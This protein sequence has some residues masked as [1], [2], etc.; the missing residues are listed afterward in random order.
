M[1][2]ASVFSFLG[3]S[4]VSDD[5]GRIFPLTITE[6]DFIGIDVK[7]IYK[8]I[9]TDVLERTQGLNEEQESVLWDNCLMSESRDG[10]VTMLAK[11]MLAK[12]E[13][14][15]VF[16]EGV[17]RTATQE[18]RS[19]I[20]ADYKKKAS[21]A[22][23]VY[24]SFKNFDVN[25]MIKVYSAIDFCTIGSLYTSQNVSKAV[26]IKVNELRSST[27]MSDSAGAKAQMLAIANG[28]KE[29]K[30]VG[31]DAKD[32]VDMAKPDLTAT[33]ASMELTAQKM[34]FYLNLPASY[35]TGILNGGLGDT[36]QADAKAIERG[37]KGYFFA[38]IKPVCKALFNVT[39]KFKSDDFQM[40]STG[41]EALKT[42]DIT[43]NDHLSGENKTLIVNKVFGLPEDEVG[44]PPEEPEPTID[45]ATGKPVVPADPNAKPA[46]G[47]KVP[48]AGNPKGA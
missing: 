26:Q 29:G 5:L 3:G 7:T 46:P 20:E 12:S 22:T 45:P 41:L 17:L 27:A 24:V 30:A 14:F 1:S 28:L 31:M 47:A 32:V 40:L 10:L 42:F 13:L 37:L 48:P 21:S 4:P 19:Q 43:S 44:D 35:V 34:S 16:K 18:E 11:A 6:A 23:G 25:D 39:L 8:K 38:I 2:F 33:K 9:L 15:L 36:G